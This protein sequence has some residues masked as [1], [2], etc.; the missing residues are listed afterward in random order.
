MYNV[1]YCVI[2]AVEYL[3]RESEG[4]KE[5]EEVFIFII[6]KLTFKYIYTW[7]KYL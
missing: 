2:K 3:F 7:K 6:T 5:W 1:Y 4:S